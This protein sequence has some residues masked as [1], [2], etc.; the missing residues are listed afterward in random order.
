MF[1]RVAGYAPDDDWCYTLRAEQARIV[2]ALHVRR[3]LWELGRLSS[4]S[5]APRADH[6][7]RHFLNPGS[8]VGRLRGYTHDNAVVASTSCFT[9]GGGPG[10]SSE[11]QACAWGLTRCMCSQTAPRSRATGTVSL[12]I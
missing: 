1:G 9:G 10:S 4:R 7:S 11:N 5:S 8:L 3:G 6:S 2:G 12:P